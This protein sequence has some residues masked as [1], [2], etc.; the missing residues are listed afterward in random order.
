[1]GT[2]M[3][4]F[5]AWA[6]VFVSCVVFSNCG[7]QEYGYDNPEGS[8]NQGSGSGYL[9]PK[10]KS[11]APL[12]R[13]NGVNMNG[14]F[15][16]T[17][18]LGSESSTD[19]VSVLR[20]GCGSISGFIWYDENRNGLFDNFDVEWG[21]EGVG[22][23]LYQDT[24]MNGVFETYIGMTV[25]DWRGFYEFDNLDGGSYLLEVDKATLPP[26]DPL[27]WVGEFQDWVLLDQTNPATVSLPTCGDL[28][29]DWRY[30]WAHSQ[31]TLFKYGPE[32]AHPGELITYDFVVYNCGTLWMSGGV[33]VY[34]E[35]INPNGDHAIWH[36]AN[37]APGETVTFEVTYEVPRD[38]FGEL[39]NSAMVVGIPELGMPPAWD[40][41]EACTNVCKYVDDNC[42]GEDDDCDGIPD[43]DYKPYTCGIGACAGLSQ[44]VDGEESCT[45]GSPSS[46]V[47][48]LIDNDCDGLTDEELGATTCGVGECQRTVQNCVNG[49]PQQCV[50]GEPSAEICDLKDNDC[51]GL[52]DED[53]G[54]TTCGVGECQRTVQNCVN[55]VP[56]QCVPGQPSAEICDLKDNDCDGATDEGF[57]ADC[58]NNCV[59]SEPCVGISEGFARDWVE[60]TNSGTQGEI[61]TV[62]NYGDKD[63]CMDA[64]IFQVS[65]ATQSHALQPFS[66]TGGSPPTPGSQ[67]KVPA[68]GQLDYYYASW[69]FANGYYQPYLG[70]PPWWCLEWGQL[71]RS[72]AI[73]LFDG[74]TLPQTLQYYAYQPTDEN[75]NGREDHVEWF[76]DYGTKAQYN[77]WEF[78]AA[79]PVLTAGKVASAG[80]PSRI[81]VVLT[82]RN[83]GAQQGSGV[84]V[85]T[86]PAGFSATNFS[87]TPTSTTINPD[88]TTTLKWDVTVKGYDDPPGTYSTT[89]FYTFG[90]LYDLVVPITTDGARVFLP[91]AKVLFNDS[92]AA[93]ESVSTKPVAIHVDVDGDGIPACTDCNDFNPN[94]TTE[95]LPPKPTC[96][97]S[98]CNSEVCSDQV[99]VTP[100]V[101][102]PE[103]A[104][105]KYTRCGNYGPNGSCGWE[106][107]SQYLACLECVKKPEICWDGIDNN[108]DGQTDEGCEW[109]KPC[110]HC[111]DGPYNPPDDP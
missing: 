93:R 84:L 22:I 60:V 15:Y 45:P 47:C 53:L 98:G 8:P 50:P 78:Q 10:P 107:N 25:T 54:S 49:V 81:A 104:C 92:I 33:T 40:I 108:C 58:K 68:K 87:L 1:M 52:T 24:D 18:A 4:S 66:H 99:V 69:T 7:P 2:T 70:K 51:D 67:L 27:P 62:R 75:R 19:T 72:G 13:K 100:C 79:H 89:I 6:F 31:L 43:D 3:K 94:V 14:R 83:L 26:L 105:L 74:E 85:D 32:I 76:G 71:G 12:I 38:A 36:F 57:P 48:D 55:G 42:D 34:D 9:F 86:V 102:K 95:C 41:A 39:C 17:E 23:R 90:L 37:L 109:E 64:T 80:G 11:P 96:Y 106:Q 59:I 101:W 16:S 20:K 110:Y 35:M 97:V 65:D 91:E 111:D 82:V 44:C 73:F 88:G 29:L 30:F 56:Q 61:V 5:H 63:I 28:T 46:E 103:F 77:Q 21:F